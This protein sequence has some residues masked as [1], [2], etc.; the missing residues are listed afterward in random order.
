MLCTEI[1]DLNLVI[2][3]VSEGG[4][5]QREVSEHR[6]E[7]FAYQCRLRQQ[8]QELKDRLD[9]VSKEI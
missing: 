8:L 1:E 4:P 5:T 7:M 3:S 2:N 6:E 9:V